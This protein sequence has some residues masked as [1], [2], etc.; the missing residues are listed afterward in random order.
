M[1][2][3]DVEQERADPT[4]LASRPD[5]RLSLCPLT[6]MRGHAGQVGVVMIA[7]AALIGVA[8]LLWIATHGV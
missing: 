4:G 6:R 5:E 3:D 1:T 8:W 2:L 7:V